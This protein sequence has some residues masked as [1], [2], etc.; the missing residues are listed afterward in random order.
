[1]PGRRYEQITVKEADLKRCGTDLKLL[2]Q[3]QVPVR[4]RSEEPP[5]LR[6][7]G[8]GSFKSL[9]EHRCRT[10]VDHRDPWLGLKN[11]EFSREQREHDLILNQVWINAIPK[12]RSRQ[13]QDSMAEALEQHDKDAEDAAATI[14]GGSSP[15]NPRTSSVTRRDTFCTS[16]SP[17]HQIPRCRSNSIRGL[18]SPSSDAMSTARSRTTSD[19]M[20]TSRTEP[21]TAAERQRSS[22]VKSRVQ[23]IDSLEDKSIFEQSEAVG[24]LAVRTAAR[25]QRF[26]LRELDQVHYDTAPRA[27]W[28]SL[29]PKSGE[30]RLYHREAAERLE[31]AFRDGRSSVPL[32]GLGR[33]V[34][35]CIVWL[36]PDDEGDRM[37]ETS[38]NGRPRDVTRLL[39]AGNIRDACIYVT[40]EDGRWRLVPEKAALLQRAAD[41]ADGEESPVELR[42]VAL[43][44]SEVVA[45]A[46]PRKLPP[47]K[48]SQRTYF[49]NPYVDEYC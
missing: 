39:V 48:P 33:A 2:R 4:T 38:Q 6:P 46:P 45:P 26:G 7:V 13:W 9:F 49:T 32:V 20:V 17:R 10:E 42:K 43:S 36:S 30:A 44:G 3:H 16:R 28:V 31:A 11:P 47:M 24:S 18:R 27:A 23:L 19:G 37:V 21:N 34:D 1:M 15:S 35:G 41:A 5:A 14:G 40:R 29:H 8:D 12:R 25:E 22:S